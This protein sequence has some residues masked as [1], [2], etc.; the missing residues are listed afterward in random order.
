MLGQYPEPGSYRFCRWLARATE[1]LEKAI[2]YDG[3][4]HRLTMCSPFVLA[5]GRNH[6]ET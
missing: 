2:K 5:S 6:S 3:R 4:R 1:R